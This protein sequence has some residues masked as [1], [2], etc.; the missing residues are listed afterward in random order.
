MKEVIIY[1]DL[2]IVEYVKNKKQFYQKEIVYQ[3]EIE[4][5]KGID[6]TYLI[7]SQNKSEEK[8]LD[9][10]MKNKNLFKS[11]DLSNSD[12]FITRI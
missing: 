2:K 7:N 12:E 8:H 5:I 10:N 4:I 3:K 6:F 1:Y 9:N 11:L